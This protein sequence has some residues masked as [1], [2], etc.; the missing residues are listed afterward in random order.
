MVI[1]GV[2]ILKEKRGLTTLLSGVSLVAIGAALFLRRPADK[3]R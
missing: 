3:Y 2:F 1:A